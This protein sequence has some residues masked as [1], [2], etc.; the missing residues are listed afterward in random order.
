MNL[1]VTIAAAAAAL[2]AV[3]VAQRA[4]NEDREAGKPKA[5]IASTAKAAKSGP[6][7]PKS[8]KVPAVIDTA[9]ALIAADNVVVRAGASTSSAKVTTVNSGASAWV[10][11]RK[12]DF[13]RLKFPG[14]TEGYV[15][16]DFL[17]PVAEQAKSAAKPISHP[18]RAPEAAPNGITYKIQKGDNDFKIAKKCG[19]NVAKLYK[20]NPG[21]K[22]SR[23]QIGQAI[24]LPPGVDRPGYSNGIK[25]NYID[26][27]RVKVNKDAVI[28][29][30]GPSTAT[31]KVTLANAGTAAN[32]LGRSG[33]WYKV[34]FAS[35]S[36]GF[37][38][39]DFLNEARPQPKVLLA[40]RTSSKQP[41]R[42]VYRYER[43]GRESVQVQ[44]L[45][46]G[47]NGNEIVAEASRH[48]GTRYVW[49]G[50]S[51]RGFDC[52]GF[53]RYVFRKA[54]GVELPR[55]SREQSKT[56]VP[57]PKSQLKPG[58]L[59]SFHTRGGSRINHSGIYIGNG[60]FIHASSGKGRVRI[61]TIEGGFYASRLAAAHRVAPTSKKAAPKP[62][63]KPEPKKD[64]EPKPEQPADKAPE[65]KS[66]EKK[67]PATGGGG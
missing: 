32:V 16:R 37:I 46:S 20:A 49:G 29:R 4:T 27:S 11:G 61:D 19:I 21:V 3:A 42:R 12:G 56:G 33:A 48:L 14:G 17:R 53:A 7:Q 24:H 51:T 5:T 6:N 54:E 50:Q 62:K 15:R 9:K 26:T 22:W 40:S 43:Q 30:K 18:T 39:G 64:V 1:R 2:L 45:P 31:P 65:P 60:K 35:G 57:V 25:I 23:L 10:K 36:T 13:Y 63:A 58:D 55:T 28:V 34:K 52:S 38:R 66:D 8:A 44:R 47:A 67:E 41:G 59:L